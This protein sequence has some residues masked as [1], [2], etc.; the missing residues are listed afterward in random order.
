MLCKHISNSPLPW[1]DAILDGK[2]IYEGRPVSKIVEWDLAIG[3]R[4]MLTDGSRVVTA[5]VIG[6]PTFFTFGEAFACLGKKLVP[7][8]GATQEWV[9]HIYHQYYTPADL[10]NGVVC[11]KLRLV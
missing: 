5:E 9:D 8:E 2:K 6:L 11:I 1:F 7:F 10:T 3:K 4:L